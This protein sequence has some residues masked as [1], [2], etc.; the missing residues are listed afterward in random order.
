MFRFGDTIK[1]AG[2]PTQRV[3]V[4][5]CHI[6]G[7]VDVGIE[8]SGA[9][10]CTIVGNTVTGT[11]GIA[12]YLAW[13]GPTD[14]IFAGNVA[15]GEGQTNRFVGYEVQPADMVTSPVPAS[16]KTQTQ[17]ISFVGNI[18]RNVSS[19]AWVYGSESNKPT[20][21]LLQGNSFSGLGRGRGIQ[22]ERATRVNVRDNLID[23]FECAIVMNDV[24]A[25]YQLYGASYVSIDNNTF[26]GGGPSLL[27]G[28]L[29]GSLNGNKFFNQTN[30][31][32]RLYAWKNCTMNG[33]LFV[34]L[35]TDQD[36]IGLVLCEHNSVG[37]VGNTLTG[38]RSMDDRAVKWTAGTI[39]LFEGKH[40]RNVITGNC[41]DG[42]KPGAFAFRDFS[43]STNNVVA[44]NIDG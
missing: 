7:V 10:G 8:C 16:M 3:S 35:G 33:N 20:H 23:G 37:M 27:F 15:E 9:I 5:S 22:I 28:N 41:A 6:S 18:A 19:G 26:T 25:G 24:R 11:R 30:H 17:R 29:G 2:K 40:E 39:G 38:N 1:G 32:I 34:N 12:A 14:C 4:S 36:R 13:N 44:N 43:S 21:V 31:A 42:A